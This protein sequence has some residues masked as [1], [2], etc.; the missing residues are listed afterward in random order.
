MSKKLIA[1]C[2]AALALAACD[3]AKPEQKV[4]ATRL[5]AKVASPRPVE[6]KNA[7]NDGGLEAPRAVAA[8]EPADPLGLA[9]DTPSVDHLARAKQL[10]GEGDA[11]GA[12]TEARRAIFSSPSDEEALELTARLSR[13][14][15][16]GE[17]AAEAWR[18]LARLRPE[19]AVPMI[20]QARALYQAKDYAAAIVAGREAIARDSENAEAHHIVGL[21]QLAM[22]E[23]AGAI[24]SFKKV[25]EI[26]PE[27]PWA[28]NNLGFAYL[29]ANENELALEVLTKAA[30][31]LPTVAYVHNNLGV[32]LER[33]GKKDEARAAYQHAMDLSPKYVKAK[34]NAARVAK[35]E[36]PDEVESSTGDSEPGS[37]VPHA[38]PEPTK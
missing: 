14:L 32:A 27:Q 38:Q 29:R 5:E 19:D 20:Q 34:L 36:V 21:S 28:M 11:K 23:L 22:N 17:V 1:A 3:D 9:H 7:M 4:V 24:A 12:L 33:A 16:Q 2:V 30:E 35:V 13:R 6:P 10:Q 37:D 18:R 8:A 15:G 25:L 31:K 26:T